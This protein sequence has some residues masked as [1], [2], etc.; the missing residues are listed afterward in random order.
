MK[1][2]D[3]YVLNQKYSISQFRACPEYLALIQADADLKESF[4]N[5]VKYILDSI[6]IDKAEGFLLDYIGWLVGTSRAFFDT[7]AYFKIN[8][9]DVNT[10]KYFWFSQPSSDFVVPS[11]SFEDIN[12]RARIKAKAGTNTSKCTREENIEIIKNM[13]F[14]DKVIIKNVAPMELDITIKGAN[15]FITQDLKS[16]IESILGQGVGIRNLT[17]EQEA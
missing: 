9:A 2:N 10:E 3:Y 15:L 14:A 4:Q 12:F 8:S 7:S 11:G 1:K 13:T 5:G 17:V 16:T 6:D